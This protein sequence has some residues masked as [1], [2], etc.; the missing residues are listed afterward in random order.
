MADE[1]LPQELIDPDGVKE[2]KYNKHG[3]TIVPIGD[4][5]EM[6][7]NQVLDPLLDE[8]G[9]QVILGRSSTAHQRWGKRGTLEIG[10]VG[11]HQ[12]KGEDFFGRKVLM[13]AAFPHITFICGKK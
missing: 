7:I 8:T 4:G 2:P 10:A 3:L 13:D 5:N 1:E 12:D 6:T 9:G 11:E